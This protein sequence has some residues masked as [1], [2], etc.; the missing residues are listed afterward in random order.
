MEVFPLA[1]FFLQLSVLTE[2]NVRGIGH[3][4][5]ETERGGERRRGGEKGGGERTG[6]AMRLIF[7]HKYI[8]HQQCSTT[9]FQHNPSFPG[10]ERLKNVKI[11][12]LKVRLEMTLSP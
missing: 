1:H 5:I 3:D 7:W 4:Q 9:K 2:G 11:R 10:R 12:K 6:H 8:R